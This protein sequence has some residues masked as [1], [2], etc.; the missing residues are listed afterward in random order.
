MLSSPVSGGKADDVNGGKVL[1][2]GERED[3]GGREAR[4][5]LLEV[6]RTEDAQ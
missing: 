3:C 2:N 4:E 6:I 1:E 5:P